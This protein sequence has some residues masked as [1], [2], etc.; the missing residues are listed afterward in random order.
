MC[1]C[2]CCGKTGFGEP[3]AGNLYAYKHCVQCCVN[4][5][6]PA[7]IQYCGCFCNS[8]SHPC[9]TVQCANGSGCDCANNGV[10]PAINQNNS[11]SNCRR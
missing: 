11:C 8:T 4:T 9:E 1:D 3:R 2:N 5:T 6:G 7:H 10:K